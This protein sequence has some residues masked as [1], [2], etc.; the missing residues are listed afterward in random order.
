MDEYKYDMKKDVKEWEVKHGDKKYAKK[1]KNP[2][3][4]IGGSSE[5]KKE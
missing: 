1:F 2:K 5:E 4:Y 3:W